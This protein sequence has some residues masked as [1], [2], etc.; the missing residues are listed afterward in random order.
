MPTPMDVFSALNGRVQ[1]DTASSQLYCILC[2]VYGSHYIYVFQLFFE[3]V[4]L[5]LVGS[6]RRAVELVRL[7]GI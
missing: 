7:Y 4:A 6:E 2:I 3:E 5:K 1:G